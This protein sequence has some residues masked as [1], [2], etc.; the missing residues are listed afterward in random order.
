[1]AGRPLAKQ[2][3][4]MVHSPGSEGCIWA[5]GEIV[6]LAGREKKK[7]GEKEVK[8]EGKR[9]ERGDWGRTVGSGEQDTPHSQAGPNSPGDL[10]TGQG[11][12]PGL[13]V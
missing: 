6:L 10:L 2:L 7:A 13:R 8:E 12:D 1:M 5:L 11:A 3:Q 4:C 9:E